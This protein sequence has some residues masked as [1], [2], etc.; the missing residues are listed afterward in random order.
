MRLGKPLL[1]LLAFSLPASAQVTVHVPDDFSTIQ[2]A[3]DAVAPG[4]TVRVRPG[5]Y[6]ENLDFRGKEITVESVDGPATTILDGSLPA[7]PDAASVVTFDSGETSASILAGFTVQGGTGTDEFGTRRGG[8][9]LIFE[10]GATLRGNLIRNNTAGLGGGVFAISSNIVLDGNHYLSNV[11]AGGYGG[12]LFAT[13]VTGSIQN[14]KVESNQSRYGAGCW[15]RGGLLTIRDTDYIGN[16][17]SEW[18]GGLGHSHTSRDIIRCT[19]KDNE[20]LSGGGLFLLEE[21]NTSVR[22]CRF[23]NNLAVEGGA[24][25]HY[26]FLDT[27]FPQFENCVFELNR[28]T[29]RGGAFYLDSDLGPSF[30]PIVRGCTFFMN[31]ADT[32]GGAISMNGPAHLVVANSIFRGNH[33]LDLGPGSKT[34]TYSNVEGGFPGVGNLDANPLFSDPAEGDYSLFPGSICVDAGENSEMSPAGSIVDFLGQIRLTDGTDTGIATIDMGAI[35]YAPSPFDSRIGNVNTATAGIEHADVLRING[36]TG[37]GAERVVHV[38]IEQPIVLDL[39]APPSRTQARHVIYAWAQDPGPLDV[40]PQDRAGFFLGWTA[41]PTVFS[42]G[43]PEP[44]VLT[45][46][47][48]HR[49]ILGIPQF[50]VGDAPTGLVE[51]PNGRPRPVTVVFQGFIEDDAAPSGIGIATSNAV[52]LKVE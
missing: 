8:G 46:E 20:A 16:I 27:S 12:G 40:S 34:V 31:T 25:H 44:T 6:F 21:S 15:L 35:E 17:A 22:S 52:V 30:A 11:A 48:G 9:I 43:S 42:G 38:G 45:N 39:L 3:I 24:V 32:A 2:A 36:S 10:S 29:A 26:E 18:G 33:P 19:F 37:G 28:A 4:S 23:T 14:E 41:L 1:L 7:D 13:L 5:T 49:P 50:E 47:F 51:L